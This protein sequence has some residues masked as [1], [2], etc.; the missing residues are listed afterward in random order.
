MALESVANLSQA[1]RELEL[2]ERNRQSEFD[3]LARTRNDAK[4]L[5]KDMIRR[6]WVTVWQAQRLLKGRGH[7]LVLGSY[8]LLEQL[9][10]G[11]MG[12]VYKAK[13]RLM[14]RTVA[15]KVIRRERL[16]HPDAVRRFHREIQAAAQLSH[17]NV[18]LA[19][20]ADRLGDVHFFAMEY[21]QGSDLGK[22]VRDR[23]P[24][25]IREACDYSRQAALGLQHAHE[26]GLVHRDIKPSNLLL[27]A[28]KEEIMRAALGG[29]IALSLSDEPRGVIKIL[30]M[31]LA[32]VAEPLVGEDPSRITHEG[33]VI[34]T[35]DFLAPE[36]ARNAS[37]VDIRADLYGLGCTLFYMLTAQTPFPGGTPTEKL[38]KH[39][40]DPAPD[41]RGLRGEAP[42]GLANVL[43]KMMAK[44]PE[45]R[46]QSPAEAAAALEP[47]SLNS[48]AARPVAP[49]PNPFA[50]SV[51]NA[52]IPVTITPEK[53]GGAIPRQTWIAVG[54]IAGASLLLVVV[55]GL[56]FRALL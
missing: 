55:F 21:V 52:P 44:K 53:S 22:I 32:R 39:A 37:T 50:D 1:V 5:A 11:G 40:I 36:Q 35:P 20:D 26:R 42:A 2:L 43:A 48:P 56:L 7:E 16:V 25:P 49:A 4:A 9:G 12:K 8:L 46:Y 15:L 41:V 19:Y 13:H 10:E 23:G 30:D 31:G 28:A 38:L 47:F 18:V 29:V 6:D 45:D 17:P 24:L 3:D 33:L 51:F 34:G 54:V 14:G 27:T